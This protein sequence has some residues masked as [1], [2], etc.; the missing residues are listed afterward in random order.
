[1]AYNIDKRKVAEVLIRS[2][3][4]IR[5]QEFN[6]GEVIIGL[7]ELIGRTIVE[8][9]KGPLQAQELTRVV[10]E[11]LDRTIKAGAEVRDRRIIIGG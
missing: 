6:H 5:A 8:V 1:M 9:A 11:H 2:N 3:E 7:S 4:A 10:V